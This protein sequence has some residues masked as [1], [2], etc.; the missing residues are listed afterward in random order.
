MIRLYR[1]IPLLIVLAI[2]ALVVYLVM[3]FRY[4]SNV[5][6]KALIDI[7]TWLNIVL[8][9]VFL[10]VLLYAL[11]E[12][13][14]LVIELGASFLATTLI[15]L[16]ITRLCNFIFKKNH[17]NFSS[18]EPVTSAEVIN[19]TLASRFGEAFKKAFGEAVKETF[20]RSNRH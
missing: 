10:I 12:G 13:N 17:P 4:T 16:G 5:A 9:G 3:S 18:D 14:Q 7:F 1:I 2:I 11:F 8:S 20:T 19:P 15:G 6:K